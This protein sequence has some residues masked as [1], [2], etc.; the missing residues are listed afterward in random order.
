ME[1]TTR[2]TL[3]SGHDIVVIGGSAG[4]AEALLE[5][6]KQL[7]ASLP[8]AVFFVYHMSASSEGWLHRMLADRTQ[9]EIKLAEDGEPIR[10]GVV[11]IARPDLHMMVEGDAVLLR[12]G[13]R[14]NRWRPAIDPLFR[15]AAIAYG[16][17]VIGIVLTG[18]LDD[19]TAG[20]AAIKR[21]GGITIVQDPH[22]A[23]H[24]QM[25]Q[26]AL[27]N[28]Q[29]DHCVPMK[30]MGKLLQDLI[31]KPPGTSASVP[32]EIEEEARIAARGIRESVPPYSHQPSLF[33]CPDCSG[34]LYKIDEKTTGGPHEIYRCLVGHGWTGQS[35]M[36]MTTEALETTLW[37]AIRLFRQ[38][39]NL[40]NSRVEREREMGRQRTA[41]YYHEEYEEALKHAQNLQELVMKPPAEQREEEHAV[42]PNYD[43]KK[44]RG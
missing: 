20:L 35:L 16:T 15:S 19:G 26:S 9:L 28:I 43:R 14:E 21:C 39:A 31:A 30:N 37:A 22:D 2:S 8:A 4:A 42:A 44:S 40:L 17:R 38:R 23:A 10:H 24:P 18:M 5:L 11:Y 3:S 1:T 33:T 12:R 6:L 34:P 29:V 32:K 25:P 27:D 7:P 41:A 36:S 13:P